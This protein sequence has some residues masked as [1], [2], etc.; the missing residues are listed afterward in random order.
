MVVK[1]ASFWSAG[2]LCLLG[3]LITACSSGPGPVLGDTLPDRDT[4]VDS[5]V[6]GDLLDV[7]TPVDACRTDGTCSSDEGVQ[8]DVKVESCTRAADCVAGKRCVPCDTTSCAGCPDCVSSCVP[9]DCV[10]EAALVD[11]TML[12]PDCIG[13]AVSVIKDGCWVCVELATCVGSADGVVVDDVAQPDVTD[14]DVEIVEPSDVSPVDTVI[15]DPGPAAEGTWVDPATGLRWQQ[16]PADKKVAW[17]GAPAY[18]AGLE[19]GGYSDWRLPRIG[20]LRSL[21]R[22]CPSTETGG[23]CGVTNT[24]LGAACKNKACDGCTENEGPNAGCYWAPELT[25]N[26]GWYWSSDLVQGST[27]STWVVVYEGAYIYQSTQLPLLGNYI[28]CV[29]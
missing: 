17:S 19:L 3:L 11:C 4:V 8:S 12:R 15:S 25:G 24:C 9:H 20:E 10:T 14:G 27:T 23:S 22:G 16:S 29:R 2:T 18:C 21:I 6:S 26:C 1:S 28:R 7:V 5:V 13:E